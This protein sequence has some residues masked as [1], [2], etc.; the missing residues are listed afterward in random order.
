MSHL[1]KD[2]N[3]WRQ[4]AQ[5]ARTVA[6]QLDDPE[7]KLSMQLIAEDYDLLASRAEQRLTPANDPATLKVSQQH[8]KPCGS[9]V[10][11]MQQHSATHPLRGAGPHFFTTSPQPTHCPTA[12]REPGPPLQ[13]QPLQNAL[14]APLPLIWAATI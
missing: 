1:L 13:L 7:A 4:R 2:P 12:A 11:R 5:E 10:R 14:Q 8:E 6:G 9:G 3:Y